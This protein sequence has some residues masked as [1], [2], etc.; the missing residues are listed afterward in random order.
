MRVLPLFVVAACTGD[1]AVIETS[2]RLVGP[3]GI[4]VACNSSDGDQCQHFA[5]LI[6]WHA[7]AASGVAFAFIKASQKDYPDFRF[8]YNWA[9]ARAQGILRGPYHFF[10]PVASASSQVS[11]FLTTVGTLAADDLPP[12]LDL[13]VPDLENPYPGVDRRQIW[14]RA[15]AWLTQVKAQ[16]GRTPIVYTTSAYLNQYRAVGVD[17][18][19]IAAY[20]LWIACPKLRQ[21]ARALA[22]V[23]VDVLAI[24][25]GRVHA[26]RLFPDRCRCLQRHRGGAAR[27]RRR[28]CR[29]V[30]GSRHRRELRHTDERR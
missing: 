21:R 9:N 29:G 14:T 11:I 19:P 8:A 10:D 13:E 7:T 27:V 22:M 6:D 3:G 15:M 28:P 1:T 18:S 17:V 30:R 26:R 4:D 25:V 2:T 23:H 5:A 24:L 20:P 12:V 16:T